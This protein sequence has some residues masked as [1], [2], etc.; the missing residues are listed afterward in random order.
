[1]SVKLENEGVKS[2]F[3]HFRFEETEQENT[4]YIMRLQ[5]DNNM[6][7]RDNGVCGHPDL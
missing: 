7:R 5:P 3:T 6:Q 1:M 2:I 4:F